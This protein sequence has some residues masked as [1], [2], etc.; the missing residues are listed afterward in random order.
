[1]PKVSLMNG[2]IQVLV[3][4]LIFALILNLGPYVCGT[5]PNPSVL[6]GPWPLKFTLTL[7]Q[8]LHL[9]GDKPSFL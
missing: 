1:M 6:I 3:I 4:F 5:N 7:A 2:N 8:T 9:R